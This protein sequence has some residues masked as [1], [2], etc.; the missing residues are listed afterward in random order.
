MCHQPPKFPR[1]VVRGGKRLQVSSLW[2]KRT[3]Q[4]VVLP[5]GGEMGAL[6]GSEP[7]LM[8]S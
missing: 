3:E 4:R 6:L 2:E 7:G 8:V 5:S 1:K